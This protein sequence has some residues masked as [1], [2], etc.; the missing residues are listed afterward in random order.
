MSNVGEDE[1]HPNTQAVAAA[2]ARAGAAGAG[3]GAG[4]LDPYRRRRRCRV[5]LSG[6]CDRQQPGVPSRRPA[7]A[8]TDQRRAPRRHRS[9]GGVA[10]RPGRSPSQPR[11][12]PGGHGPT[13]RRR[14]TR[15]PVRTLI[16]TALA[17]F[18]VVWAAA[19]TS[20][21]VFPTT[22]YQELG[23]RPDQGPRPAELREGPPPAAVA[24]HRG[25]SERAA[26][27]PVFLIP[28]GLPRSRSWAIPFMARPQSDDGSPCIGR[29]AVGFCW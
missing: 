3:A 4:G 14:R 22:S 25:R 2:L 10:R 19:G 9:L 24:G 1:V 18:P 27:P 20:H 8:G 7:G 26:P 11:A 21:T 5:G 6:R 23:L 15:R 13:R 28:L 17:A 16:D 29:A 12:G